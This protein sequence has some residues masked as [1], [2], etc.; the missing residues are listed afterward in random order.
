MI[1]CTEESFEHGELEAGAEITQANLFSHSG[2]AMSTNGCEEARAMMGLNQARYQTT[3]QKKKEQR[4]ARMVSK[5]LRNME[6]QGVHFQNPGDVHRIDE[7]PGN[8]DEIIRAL[9][10]KPAFQPVA[11]LHDIACYIHKPQGPKGCGYYQTQGVC[12]TSL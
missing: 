12:L 7:E 6:R 3:A 9:H 4:I 11:Y 2:L 5:M 10:S 1:V 8:L